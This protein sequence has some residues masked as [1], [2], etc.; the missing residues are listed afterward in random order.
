MRAGAGLH[1]AQKLTVC[2][3]MTPAVCVREL[4]LRSHGSYPFARRWLG[5]LLETAHPCHTCKATYR[6]FLPT[7]VAYILCAYVWLSYI[8]G[9]GERHTTEEDHCTEAVKVFTYSSVCA[10][11]RQSILLY[12]HCM[13]SKELTSSSETAP[14][15]QGVHGVVGAY[16]WGAQFHRIHRHGA[17]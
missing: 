14:K 17:K 15:N 11:W 9:T 16:F 5:S 6:T 13:V 10:A 3:I 8:T 4:G 1:I 7:T 2:V 12:R